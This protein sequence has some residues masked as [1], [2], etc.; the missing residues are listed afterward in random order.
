[1]P[2][3]HGK[4]TFVSFL[5]LLYVGQKHILNCNPIRLYPE[6]IR[7][8]SNI[9]FLLLVISHLVSLKSLLVG[10]IE[11]VPERATK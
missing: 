11:D 5:L 1:M 3:G 6:N 7:L 4:Y 10:N 2:S 9:S 8:D